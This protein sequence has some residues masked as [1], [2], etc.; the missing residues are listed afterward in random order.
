MNLNLPSPVL[1]IGYLRNLN[2]RLKRILIALDK[3][4]EKHRGTSA[5]T[6]GLWSQGDFVWNTT[7]SELGAGGS[8]YVILGWSCVAAGE[9]G[10]WVESRAL[11]GA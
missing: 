6:T 2:A 8:K 5:P 1:D 4:S 11:T 9:P 3:Q 10:T 7:P